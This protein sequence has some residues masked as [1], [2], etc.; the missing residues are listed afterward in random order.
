MKHLQQAINESQIINLGY[1]QM[2]NEAWGNEFRN[3]KQELKNIFAAYD[4]AKAAADKSKKFNPYRSNK[5]LSDKMEKIFK[6][7]PIQILID[8]AGYKPETVMKTIYSRTKPAQQK[9]DYNWYAYANFIVDGIESGK[10]NKDDMVKWWSEYYENISKSNW[11]DIKYICRQIDPTQCWNPYTPKDDSVLKSFE[12]NPANIVWYLKTNRLTYDQKKQIGEFLADPV[13]SDVLKKSIKAVSNSILK[14]RPS[15]AQGAAKNIAS[16]IDNC[17]YDGERGALKDILADE[18]KSSHNVVRYQGSNSVEGC[19][20]SSVVGLILKV[21]NQLY[22][23]EV[24]HSTYMNEEDYRPE[25]EHKINV[26]GKVSDDTLEGFLDDVNNLKFIIND[27]G[28]SKNDSSKTSGVSNSSFW[29]SY[30]H[31]FEVI[32]K[33]GDEEVFHETFTNVT[34]G[35]S[36]FSGGWG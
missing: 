17:E 24:F 8:K 5:G 26:K 21:I 31:D 35:S 25:V 34:V 14:A 22:G 32:C 19:K 18:Y 4:K 11:F 3:F 30:D 1:S 6:K 20:G 27:L 23:F 2:I 9:E 33:K 28:V 7:Y 10:L 15:F 12:T 29:T 36:Y 13:N 16:L